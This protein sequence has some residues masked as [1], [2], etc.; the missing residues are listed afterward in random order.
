[1]AALARIISA[2]RVTEILWTVI[3]PEP[4]A[5]RRYVYICR[6]AR[7]AVDLAKSNTVAVELAEEPDGRGERLEIQKSMGSDQPD[8]IP[9]VDTYSLSMEEGPSTSTPVTCPGASC[10]RSAADRRRRDI[11]TLAPAPPSPDLCESPRTHCQRRCAAS[12]RTER[13]NRA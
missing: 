3:R 8:R 4:G 1:M 5:G 6:E 12:D 7:A 11:T 10:M 13:T 2:A 9:R